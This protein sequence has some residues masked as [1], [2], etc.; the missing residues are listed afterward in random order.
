M[1]V[2]LIMHNSLLQMKAYFCVVLPYL[3]GEQF[4]EISQKKRVEC[5]TAS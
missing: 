2:C 4:I 5:R 1:K 3:I